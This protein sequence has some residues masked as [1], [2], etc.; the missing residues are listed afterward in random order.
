[1]HYMSEAHATGK[2]MQSSAVTMQACSLELKYHY[3]LFNAIKSPD[4]NYPSS[5]GIT[6]RTYYS[7]TIEVIKRVV[8]DIILIGYNGGEQFIFIRF[9]K[10]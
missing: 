2:I 9:T 1:M 10:A 7:G 8:G 3:I 4:F 6:I 5:S